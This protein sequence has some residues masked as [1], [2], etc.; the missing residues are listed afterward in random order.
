MLNIE[1]EKSDLTKREKNILN[2]IVENFV[3]HAAPVGSKF[4]SQNTDISLSSASI[5]NVM[6]ELE[7]RG[8]I[9]HPHTSAGRLPTDKGYR[10][11][12]DSLMQM[13][14]LSTAEKDGI[15]ENLNRFSRDVSY[16]L[17][18]ASQT[19]ARI[20]NLLGVVLAPRFFEGIFQK[21]EL[22]PVT[23]KKILVVIS[24]KSGLVKTITM[25][26]EKDVPR[27]KLEHTA[28]VINERLHGLTL[29]EIKQTIDVR[30]KNLDEGDTSFI[31]LVVDSSKILFDF[32]PPGDLHIGGASNIIVQPEFFKQEAS[33][34]ITE[35][36]D[37]REIMIHLLNQDDDENDTQGDAKKIRITIGEEN[38]DIVM[39][40]C[41]LITASYHVGEIF[42][43]VGVLG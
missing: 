1:A 9:T 8:Y 22:V 7:Q 26:L 6:M 23:E 32:S 31:D 21:M 42:G 15:V 36:L 43:T 12:V 40:H 34:D 3:R 10:F 16:I 35:L 18:A 28:N 5:R 41:S 39:Q 17:E 19:L 13:E 33:K 29:Q 25:E 14:N 38:K 2:L 27:E 11:Y 30:L 24:I 20:S 37:D 4:I